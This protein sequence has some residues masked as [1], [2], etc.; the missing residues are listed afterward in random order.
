MFQ[1]IIH[2]WYVKHVMCFCTPGFLMIG[3]NSVEP[4]LVSLSISTKGNVAIWHVF[5]KNP[6]FSFW[7]LI[8]SSSLVWQNVVCY[9]IYTFARIFLL[10]FTVV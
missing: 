10:N 8:D 1:R 6:M 3:L 4:F 5:L 7:Q 2:Y 9:R